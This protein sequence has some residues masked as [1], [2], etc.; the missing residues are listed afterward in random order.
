MGPCQTVT[1]KWATG[2]LHNVRGA[3]K[4]S[5]TPRDSEASEQPKYWGT[6][7][8]RE[9]VATREPQVMWNGQTEEGEL[10]RAFNMDFLASVEEAWSQ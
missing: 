2:I 6:M 3:R 5:T 4:K 10:A 9:C 1:V 7:V 8:G